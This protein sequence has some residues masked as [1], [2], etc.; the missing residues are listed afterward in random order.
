MVVRFAASWLTRTSSVSYIFL[1]DQS[2]TA[3]EYCL[4][5]TA[6]SRQDTTLLI[7]GAGPTGLAAALSLVK[8]GFQDFI[9]V[10]EVVVR[11]PA[12]RAM[13]IHAATLEVRTPSFLLFMY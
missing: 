7:V 6:M 5:D 10:D 4:Y 12:S 2:G 13:T 11:P 3:A 8:H 9:I 1:T